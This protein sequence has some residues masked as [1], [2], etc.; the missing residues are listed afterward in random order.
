[1]YTN[2]L[3]IFGEILSQRKSTETEGILSIGMEGV[4]K[5]SKYALS[6]VKLNTTW[7]LN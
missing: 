5:L 6:K 4:V 2:N 3:Y 1:L 7:K